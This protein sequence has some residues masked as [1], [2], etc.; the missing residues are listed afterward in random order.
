MINPTQG[1]LRVNTQHSQGTDI[2][3]HAPS[4]IRTRRP[5]NRAVMDPSLKPRGHWR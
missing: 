1:P 2:P 4:G 5:S 3:V